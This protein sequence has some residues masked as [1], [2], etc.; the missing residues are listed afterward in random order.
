MVFHDTLPLG[1]GTEYGGCKDIGSCQFG[2]NTPHFEFHDLCIW[3]LDLRYLIR[4]FC[5]F[6]C[7]KKG[8]GDYGNGNDEISYQEI[9]DRISIA[10]IAGA[11]HH[12]RRLGRRPRVQEQ[13]GESVMAGKIVLYWKHIENSIGFYVIFVCKSKQQ[14]ILDFRI[15]ISLNPL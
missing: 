11:A 15:Q 5:S 7:S 3:P 12:R 10:G 4:T 6:N 2:K 8:K 1:Q 13:A 9:V 14:V